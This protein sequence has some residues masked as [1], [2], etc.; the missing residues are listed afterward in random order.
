M[1]DRK[2]V[3][4]EFGARLDEFQEGYEWAEADGLL[5]SFILVGEL[6][7]IAFDP[8]TA[9]K[10]MQAL[11]LVTGPTASID[12]SVLNEEPTMDWREFWNDLDAY[13]DSRWSS[14]MEDAHNVNAFAYLGIIPTW[15]LSDADRSSK[16]FT[17]VPA[18]VRNVV[19]RL[20]R[21][22]QLLPK[23]L[24][25]YGI[26]A[27]ERTCLAATGRLKIDAGE[28]LSV[29][30]LAAVTQ[31]TTK[32]LQ[33]AIYAKSA[34]APIANKDGTIT[35]AAAQRWLEAREYK[36]SIWQQFLA[37]NDWEEGGQISVPTVA[38]KPTG[39]FLF[40]PEAR[41]GTIFSPIACRRGGKNG[42]PYYTVGPKGC[43]V[44][45][46][47]YEEALAALSK[48]SNPRWRRP[49]EHG[50]F[51]IVSA[52]RWRRLNREELFSI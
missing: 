5:R 30:E 28:P 47:D 9:A 33:N 26:D 6:L 49:N 36:P 13:N 51:G 42:T 25:L 14:L 38:D 50:S 4:D 39:D 24:D 27:I 12:W 32:R 45:Y 17:D 46:E 2:S 20:N 44:D 41:D 22:V 8:L 37:S 40:V 21:F 3:V 23:S 31:V 15:A 11:R 34:D 1:I 10:G 7:D 16:Q 52:E 35:A 43:E 19:E 48:L 29:H 18:Y